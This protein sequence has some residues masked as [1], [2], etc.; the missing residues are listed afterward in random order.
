MLSTNALCMYLLS[1]FVLYIAIQDYIST[2]RKKR[3]IVTRQ[4]TNKKQKSN[5]C[6]DLDDQL[7]ASAH[8]EKIMELMFLV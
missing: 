6:T 3:T 8:C 5:T 7:T 4:L 1:D 2:A